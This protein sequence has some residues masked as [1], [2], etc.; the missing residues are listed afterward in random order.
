[1][2]IYDNPKQKNLSRKIGFY[3][4]AGLFDQAKKETNF[5]APDEAHFYF[6]KI[7]L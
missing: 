6:N 4:R 1:V 3:K 5:E 2:K 7:L